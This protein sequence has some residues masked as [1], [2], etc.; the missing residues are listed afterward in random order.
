[1]TQDHLQL[2]AAISL[3]TQ[4]LFHC[5]ELRL[6]VFQLPLQHADPGLRLVQM[7]LRGHAPPEKAHQ[8]TDQQPNDWRDPNQ[9]VYGWLLGRPSEAS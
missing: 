1:L 4:I 2:G 5:L 3:Q 7:L 6:F 8:D 9:F